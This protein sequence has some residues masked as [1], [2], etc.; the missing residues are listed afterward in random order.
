MT[1]MGAWRHSKC[2]EQN[3]ADFKE[4]PTRHPYIQLI[5]R[6][7]RDLD[8]LPFTLRLLIRFGST[9]S[10]ENLQSNTLAAMTSNPLM[11]RLS[12]LGDLRSSAAYASPLP[13]DG[14]TH[15]R[16]TLDEQSATA[17]DLAMKWRGYDRRGELPGQCDWCGI[18]RDEP[19]QKYN[20]PALNIN[21]RLILCI[22][23]RRYVME[24]APA[25]RLPGM[26]EELRRVNLSE[27]CEICKETAAFFTFIPYPIVRFVC[28]SCYANA[29]KTVQSL[30]VS[31]TRTRLP[32]D[33]HEKYM[34][35]VDRIRNDPLLIPANLRD[36]LNL[37]NAGQEERD[38]AIQGH[39]TSLATHVKNSIKRGTRSEM[40]AGTSKKVC[41]TR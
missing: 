5:L 3:S 24:D 16:A 2:G 1:D 8:A 15:I 32:E 14:I 33:N 20:K 12:E 31:Q 26:C 28:S 29:G 7:R 13:R 39:R 9:L 19:G 21:T 35:L 23:D 25:Y 18:R 36:P 34:S 10:D 40:A 4:N 41:I 38:E 37:P 6:L 30:V 27:T 11:E 17:R 22:R